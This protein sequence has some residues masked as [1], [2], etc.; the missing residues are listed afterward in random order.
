M[1]S[2][3]YVLA[4]VSA[5]TS[6]LAAPAEIIRRTPSSTGNHGGYWYS[7]WTDNPNSVTY[8]NQNGGQFSVQWNGNGNFV[9]GKGWSTGAAR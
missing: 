5:F 9:G 3:T 4:A 8:T 6:V 1:V 2:F 7:F